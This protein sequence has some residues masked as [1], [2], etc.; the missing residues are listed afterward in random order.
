VQIGIR[1]FTLDDVMKRFDLP[2]LMSVFGSLH[3]AQATCGYVVAANQITDG[4][5]S[6]FIRICAE[7]AAFLHAVGFEHSSRKAYI[8]KVRLERKTP[9]LHPSAIQAEFRSLEDSINLDMRQNKFAWIDSALS[10]FAQAQDLLGA[11]VSECFPS[12]AKDIS[13]AGDCIA[14]GCD[15]AAVFHLMHIVEWGLRA[16]AS[17]LGLSKVVADRKRGKTVPLAYAQWEQILNQLPDKI[18]QKIAPLSRGAKKQKAQEFYYSTL[19]EIEGL[20]DAWRNHLM[21]TRAV[22]TSADAL[23]VFSHVER[24]MQSLAEHGIKESKRK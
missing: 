8:L 11:K 6:W 4:D 13:D 19:K 24:F 2:K 21:H 22:Y 12:A 1:V 16:F 20:K 7:S 17:H 5:H 23:A 9:D 15:S 3:S 18:E 14:L 10:R